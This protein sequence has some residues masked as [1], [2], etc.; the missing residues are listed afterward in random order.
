MHEHLLYM[1]VSPSKHV[2]IQLIK[3]SSQ[4]VQNKKDNKKM[5]KIIW[6]KNKKQRQH[7]NYKTII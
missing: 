3:I 7:K 4:M 5:T 1:Y 2:S 6:K